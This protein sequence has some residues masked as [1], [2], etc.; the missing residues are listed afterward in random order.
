MALTNWWKRWQRSARRPI[1][2]ERHSK[3]V[4]PVVEL[5]EDRTLLSTFSVIN[6][7][8]AGAG[9]LRQAILDANANNGADVIQFNI[10]GS[11]VHAIQPLTGLPAI[12]DAVSISG[13]GTQIQIDGSQAGFATGLAITADNCTVDSLSIVN[14]T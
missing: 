11:G 2:S 5:L 10:A 4:R 13:V 8:D 7:D 14:F 3:L 12:T 9:S 6:T 1:R